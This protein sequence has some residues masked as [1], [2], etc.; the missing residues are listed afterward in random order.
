[1][2][3]GTDPDKL[4]LGP[5]E[6][7]AVRIVAVG[8]EQRERVGDAMTKLEGDVGPGHAYRY[9]ASGDAG[10]VHHLLFG[11]DFDARRDPPA[12]YEISIEGEGA[13]AGSRIEVPAVLQPALGAFPQTVSY[14]LAIHV[15]RAPLAPAQ[16][17]A[18]PR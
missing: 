11:F 9:T 4:Y 18:T 13:N 2:R 8:T 12:R 14:A 10:A 1:M 3:Q 6:S 16:G 15:E 5:G 7:I 17:L